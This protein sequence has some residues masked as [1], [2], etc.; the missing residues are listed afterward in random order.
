MKAVRNLTRAFAGSVPLAEVRPLRT[1]VSPI[2]KTGKVFEGKV[3]LGHPDVIAFLSFQVSDRRHIVAVYVSTY[4]VLGP[5]PEERYRLTIRRLAT[6]RRTA[7]LS[8]PVTDRST[9]LDVVT[10]DPDTVQVD[11]DVADHPRLLI[12]D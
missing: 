7:R 4:D 3:S 9:G 1:D 2:G 5:M 11:V 10:R 8:D 12:L 6:P